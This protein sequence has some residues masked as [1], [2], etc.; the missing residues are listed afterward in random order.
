MAI[1]KSYVKLPEGSCDAEAS[2]R[3]ADFLQSP[4]ER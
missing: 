2:L 1:L 3:D 4:L